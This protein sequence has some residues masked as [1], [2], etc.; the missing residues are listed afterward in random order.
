VNAGEGKLSLK[1]LRL[2]IAKK[3]F[4]FGLAIL[5]SVL[6]GCGGGSPQASQEQSDLALLQQNGYVNARLFGLMTFAIST[7]SFTYPTDLT[8][9]SVPIVWMGQVFNGS[10]KGGPGGYTTDF[11]HG[12]V[13]PDGAWL[14]SFSY[15]RQI[16]R[17]GG[18]S[19]YYSVELKNIPLGQVGAAKPGIF[20]QKGDVQKYVVQISYLGGGFSVPEGS[21]SAYMYTDWTSTTEGRQPVLGV[22]FEKAPSQTLAGAQAPSG[23]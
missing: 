10:T 14:L 5:L 17:P 2:D 15:S 6:I 22:T 4:A 9:S 3:T 16:I 11:V 13:S 12:G 1:K 7:T 20:E 23:M 18:S 19:T 8:I 21:S